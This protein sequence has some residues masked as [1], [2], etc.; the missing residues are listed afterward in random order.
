MIRSKVLF[1]FLLAI[2]VPALLT[3]QLNH[4]IYLQTENKQPFYAKLD[5]KVLSSSASG[6][7]IIPKLKDST[8]NIEIGF[9]R[10]ENSS[11]TYTCDVNN[12]DA[13]YLIKNFGDKGRGLFNLQTL[14]VVMAGDMAKKTETAK[15]EKTDDFSNM[16]SEVVND[17]SIK[18]ADKPVVKENTG[19]IAKP[20]EKETTA[21]TSPQEDKPVAK[22][23]T[24]STIIKKQSVS[25]ESGVEIIYIDVTSDK[26][27][28]IKIFIPADK[29]S[30]NPGIIVSDQPAK[31]VDEP[32]TQEKEKQNTETT[33]PVTGN[34]PEQA[35]E[36]VKPKE[37]TRLTPEADKKFLPI[38]MKAEGKTGAPVETPVVSPMINSNCKVNA[39]DEDFLKLRKKMA[40]EDSDDAMIT[41]AQKFLKAKCYT[42]DQIK[43]LSFLF[44]KDEGKYRFFDL[45]YQFVS[46]SHNFNT[47]ESQLTDAY[48]IS[49]F[50]AMVRH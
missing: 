26:Q 47:L 18:Q 41:V 29:E 9:P 50:K 16:L 28:T 43:N 40:G 12:K 1:L 3:A 21:I 7:L 20:A 39:T 19:A 11:Q 15:V 5:K 34:K 22:Q 36:D 49:R 31:A 14:E 8:Y 10:S 13:G 48:Y 38:E 33:N 2:A 46:D 4:F 6:Y 17:P 27:D 44:L 35:K 42:T 24:R 32:I 25:S 37:E 45:A 23:T 30:D